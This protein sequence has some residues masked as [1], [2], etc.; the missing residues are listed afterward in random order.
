[1]TKKTKTPEI[2]EKECTACGTVK[3]LD[4]FGALKAGKYG[5]MSICKECNQNR[6][7]NYRKTL[8]TMVKNAPVGKTPKM[9]IDWAKV[10]VVV[11][12]VRKGNEVSLGDYFKNRTKKENFV[13]EIHV[14]D[15]VKGSKTIVSKHKLFVKAENWNNLVSFKKFDTMEHDLFNADSDKAWKE[16]VDK[17]GKEFAKE[18]PNRPIGLRF[19]K[20]GSNGKQVN[21]GFGLKS[22]TELEKIFSEK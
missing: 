17:Y 12:E 21:C 15:N 1:M 11:R 2:T 18:N 9:M 10:P 14:W 19:K 7:K 20:H 5:K 6:S 16:F 8:E 3:P 13:L 4:E 22:I